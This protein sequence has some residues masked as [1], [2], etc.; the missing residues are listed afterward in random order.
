MLL[1]FFKFIWSERLSNS[2]WGSDVLIFSEFI[3]IVSVLFYNFIEFFILLHTFLVTSF[4][5]YKKL[6]DASVA[7]KSKKENGILVHFLWRFIN[8]LKP[9]SNNW[10]QSVEV[11]VCLDFCSAKWDCVTKMRNP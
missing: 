6:S 3:N 11:L 8:S 9:I 2:L 5:R 10:M 1:S 7:S 4:F